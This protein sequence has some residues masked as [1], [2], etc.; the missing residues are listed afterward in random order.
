MMD[1][2]FWPTPNCY[3]ISVMLE[4]IGAK[5]RLIPIDIGAGA[6]F[7]PEFARLNPNCKIPVLVDSDGPEGRPLKLTESGAMLIYLTEKGG[8]LLGESESERLAVLQWLMF[9]IASVGPMLGQLHHFRMR[10]PEAYPLERY[11][12]EAKRIYGLLDTRLAEADYLAGPHYSIADIATYPWIALHPFDGE[13]LADY[14]R[15]QAWFRRIEA[16]P[17][18][19]RGYEALRELREKLMAENLPKAPADCGAPSS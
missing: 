5:Y 18:V 1:L 13:D 3:K 7:A 19:A 6:Q 14:P 8:R 10:P 15:L 9:Q 11:G 17:A 12:R 16:R 4:E 2:Y